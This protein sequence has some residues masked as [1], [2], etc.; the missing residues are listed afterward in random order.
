MF[1]KLFPYTLYPNFG[2][3]ILI[4]S[5]IS[6]RPIRWVIILVTLVTLSP[7]T[8]DYDLK[9]NIKSNALTYQYN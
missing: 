4:V 5:R 6:C 9:V 2:R 1:Q 8:R 7:L 3:G